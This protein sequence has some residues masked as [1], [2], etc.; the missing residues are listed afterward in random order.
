MMVGERTRVVLTPM[1]VWVIG[2]IVGLLLVSG[3]SRE[4]PTPED[5]LERY[6]H[7]RTIM[8][9]FAEVTAVAE[10]RGV[11]EQCVEAAYGRLEDVN[12]L[13][14][15]Y[16]PESE[17]SR[18]NRLA[19]GETMAVSEETFTC[20]QA[21][22]EV[23]RVSGG[24]FDATCRPLVS[25]WKASA[26]A[27]RLPGEAALSEVLAGVGAEHVVLEAA[28][29]SVGRSNAG[30]QVDLGGIAKGYALDLA[31]E[32]MRER[33]A[34]GGL[35]NV[36]GDVRA[37]GRQEDGEAWRI[38][39]KHPFRDGLV[40]RIVLRD[41]AVA[42]SGLQ[43]RFYEIEGQ[44]YSHIIDPRDG[45]PVAQAPSVTV[46]A[47]DGMTADAWATVFSV[48]SVTEGQSLL[49]SEGAPAVEVLWISGNVED[50]EMVRTDG[51]GAYAEGQQGR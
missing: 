48:L 13:M 12:R 6:G 11:A 44:R 9:T 36:G 28:T 34:V 20:L 45:R 5:R 21:A 39:V 22:L 37:F 46:I 14:S 31:V 29:R 17:I 4:R 50:V 2:V 32:A 23:S 43:Q 35:V 1:R 8:G 19:V 40:D 3:C 25:L 42:T 49:D 10:S 47:D 16:D 27:G 7:A 33:G 24:A 51:F 38:G 26:K 18:I 15:D 30:T 41:K